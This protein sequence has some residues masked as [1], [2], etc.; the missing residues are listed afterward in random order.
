MKRFAEI[1]MISLCVAAAAYAA[2]KSAAEYYSDAAFQY[3]ESRLPSAEITCKEGLS[4]Y[5]SDSKLQMLLDRI[6]QAKDKQKQQNQ[7]Q[8]KD[9]NQ[10]QDKNQ[11][12]KNK[13]NQDKNQQDQNKNDQNQ[14]KDQQNQDQNK[15][16][17][18][19]QNQDQ[20]KGDQGRSSSSGMSSQSNG[21]ERP[22][23][24][25]GS[26]SKDD[27]AQLLKDFDKENGERKPWRPVQG[28]AVPDKDW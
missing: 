20:N 10:N 5:P 18:K 1:L 7:N 16:K 22:Q 26:L 6:Q 19:N 11:N 28:R 21:G 9:K 14:N 27:A 8:N 12:D 2:P 15:D 17:N 23:L 3:I 25:P 24:P 4:Y 13:Q